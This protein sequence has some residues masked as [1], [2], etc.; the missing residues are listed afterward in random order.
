MVAYTIII[1]DNTI[2]EHGKDTKYWHPRTQRL[3]HHIHNTTHIAR[4][5]RV[6]ISHSDYQVNQQPTKQ[7]L[8]LAWTIQHILIPTNRRLW[9]IHMSIQMNKYQDYFHC[10]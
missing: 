1:Y 6:S 7:D 8:I 3:Y 2:L 9:Y 5:S 4:N 10:F